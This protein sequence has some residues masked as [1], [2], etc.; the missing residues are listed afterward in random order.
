MS[1]FPTYEQPQGQQAE[2]GSNGSFGQLGHAQQPAQDTA[3]QATGGELPTPFSNGNGNGAPT[4]QPSES[5]MSGGA[6][7]KTTLWY[8]R[9]AGVR[10]MRVGK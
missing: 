4:G 1:T 10:S 5:A 2:E 3:G 6:E 9:L 8:A 7:S